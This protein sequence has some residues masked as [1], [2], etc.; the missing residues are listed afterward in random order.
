MSKTLMSIVAVGA[1]VLAGC[2]DDDGGGGLSDAQ[3]GAVDAAMALGDESGLDLDRGCVEDLAGDLSDE[4]A[5]IL[6]DSGDETELS[7]DG[8]ATSDEILNC[9]DQ[10]SLIDFF[11]SNMEE[12][13]LPFDEECV[14]DA[15]DGEDLTPLLE[16]AE[17]PGQEATELI[18]A[19]EACFAADS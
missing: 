9:L 3:S 19:V 13:G 6:A 18:T 16:D 7:A 2:G 5:Q 14:R 4:D 1:L 15:L 11:I 17:T 12:S 8:Q 10:S